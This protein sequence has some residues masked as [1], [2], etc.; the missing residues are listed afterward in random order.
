MIEMVRATEWNGFED[1]S[2][3]INKIITER[4]ANL[5]VSCVETPSTMNSL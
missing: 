5:A 2:R 1:V 4:V 3:V